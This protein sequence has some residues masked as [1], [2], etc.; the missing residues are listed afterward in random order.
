MPI[1]TPHPD[2]A[3]LRHPIDGQRWY[4]GWITLDGKVALFCTQE[5]IKPHTGSLSQDAQYE[6][7][8]WR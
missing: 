5:E 6:V 3:S 8:P 1:I 7:R 2:P 4:R